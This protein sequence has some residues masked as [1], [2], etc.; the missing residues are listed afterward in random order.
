M[1][2]VHFISL[3]AYRLNYYYTAADNDTGKK[4][5]KYSSKRC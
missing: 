4:K 2:G 1:E 3:F 5:S